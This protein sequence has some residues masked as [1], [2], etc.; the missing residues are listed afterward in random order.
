MPVGK[1]PGCSSCG[2]HGMCSPVPSPGEPAGFPRSSTTVHL[3]CGPA[4]PCL[5]A[6]SRRDAAE[7]KLQAAEARCARMESE[8]KDLKVRLTFFCCLECCFVRDALLSLGRSG[9]ELAGLACS[10]SRLP[11]AV[12]AQ[13]AACLR[14]ADHCH[15]P[16][17]G[18]W[19][20]GGSTR[21]RSGWR[22]PWLRRRPRSMRPRRRPSGRAG[23][24]K[25]MPSL[26]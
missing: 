7:R 12:H 9:R 19:M 25:W 6:E 11:A 8:I 22:A 13:S 17:L 15:A 14:R 5:P 2:E 4:A 1:R 23:R 18:R 21:R 20:C 26:T 24:R 16:V 10:A 3:A